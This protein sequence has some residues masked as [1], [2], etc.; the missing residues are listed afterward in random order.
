[1]TP[2][3]QSKRSLLIK[4]S[5]AKE[6][7]KATPDRSRSRGIARILFTETSEHPSSRLDSSIEKFRKNP[8]VGRL[9]D[10]GRRSPSQ[11]TN[12][13]NKISH[14]KSLSNLNSIQKVD[15]TKF[16]QILIKIQHR[17]TLSA[18]HLI[19]QHRVSR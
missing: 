18:F 17:R 10:S 8:S 2:N 13:I 12:K 3:H 15:R 16:F 1:M 11:P 9:F 5:Q 7:L 19:K 4:S 14:K 6:S